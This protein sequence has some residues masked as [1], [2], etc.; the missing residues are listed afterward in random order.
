MKYLNYGYK[1]NREEFKKNNKEKA[2][3]GYPSKLITDKIWMEINELTTIY[4]R[5]WFKN[6]LD[7]M[8]ENLNNYVNKMR[9]IHITIFII[10]AIIIIFAYCIVWKNYE[11]KLIVMLKRSVNLINLIPEEI[12]YMIV[13]KLNE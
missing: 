12:K 11:N 6:I 10:L 5:Y 1:E 2:E 3:F 4:I 9:L 7:L 8:M 13:T